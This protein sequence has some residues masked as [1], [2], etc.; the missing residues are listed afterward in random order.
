MTS[1]FIEP[2]VEPSDHLSEDDAA[3][4]EDKLSLGAALLLVM[5]IAAMLVSLVWPI[6]WQ[7]LHH[8]QAL[9]TPPPPFFPEA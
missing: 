3:T 6:V 5:L 4:G 8:Y 2:P 7:L 1:P 9:P